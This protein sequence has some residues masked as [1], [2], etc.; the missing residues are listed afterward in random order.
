M[1]GYCYNLHILTSMVSINILE[2]ILYVHIIH[3]KR[4][5]CSVYDLHILTSTVSINILEVILYVHIIHDK[6]S[7]CSV[8]DLHILTSMVSINTL[9]VILLFFFNEYL[10]QET[11]TRTPTHWRLDPA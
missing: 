3:D 1:L 11:R 5:L 7:L 9:E 8:Y 2:V 10:P 4:S 6:R